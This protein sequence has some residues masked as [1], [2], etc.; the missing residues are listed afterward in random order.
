MNLVELLQMH[1]ACDVSTEWVR[2]LD[3]QS[4]ENA[5]RKCPRGDW[6]IWIAAELGV[7]RK[8]IVQA[9]CIYARTVLKYVPDGEDRP[10]VAI[11]TAERWA[12]GEAT[13]DTAITAAYGAK[14]AWYVCPT[15]AASH[16]AA[17][18]YLA[19]R[20]ASCVLNALDAA[21]YVARA[22]FIAEGTRDASL[23]ELSY[24]V[25]STVPF[26]AIEEL[27]HV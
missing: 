4:P 24:I 14:K 23:R 13:L 1:Y 22:K 16:A 21:E 3:D 12:R 15:G 11:E 27:I 20:T 6:L 9:V 5:W 17:A 10:R 26:S 8:L 2:S 7:D 19:A 18:A 25:R